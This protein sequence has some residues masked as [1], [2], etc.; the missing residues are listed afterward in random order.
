MRQYRPATMA[1]ATVLPA[2]DAGKVS[3]AVVKL[4]MIA[5]KHIALSVFM[6]AAA[7]AFAQQLPN[8]SIEKHCQSAGGLYDYCMQRSHE[9]YGRL[10]E[11]WDSVP[12]EDRKRCLKWLKTTK[13]PDSYY[14]LAECVLGAD[15]PSPPPVDGY[16]PPPPPPWYYYRY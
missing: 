10:Q 3:R 8:F 6:L 9:V 14:Q 2:I 1:C 5:M 11:R 15:M 13:K 16:A 4:R 12:P 7:P